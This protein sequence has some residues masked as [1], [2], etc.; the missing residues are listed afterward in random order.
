MAVAEAPL[1]YS[2]PD[3]LEAQAVSLQNLSVADR[4][5][6]TMMVEIAAF[7][8][9]LYS[10][11]KILFL[12][13]DGE[14]FYD[15]LRILI[16]A[17]EPSKL[18]SIQLMNVNRVTIHDPLLGEYLESQGLSVDLVKAG[19]KVLFFDLGFE[20]SLAWAIRDRFPVE[21]WPNLE[22][23][24]V[25]SINDLAPSFSL[26]T[27]IRDGEPDFNSKQ[28][29][30]FQHAELPKFSG[31]ASRY[32]Y[33][34]G[35]IQPIVFDNKPDDSDA[36]IDRNLAGLYQAQ[37][38]SFLRQTDVIEHYRSLIGFWHK[39]ENIL[40]TGTLSDLKTFASSHLRQK[41]AFSELENRWD[42]K[43][44]KHVHFLRVNDL[45]DYLQ[46]RGDFLD[47]VVPEVEL[48]HRITHDR[49]R[50]YKA[51]A[52]K[53]LNDEAMLMRLIFVDPISGIL[54]AER[55]GMRKAVKTAVK[56]IHW[57]YSGDGRLLMDI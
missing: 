22:S 41:S 3:V 12:A 33:G 34:D 32:G 21:Y 47:K 11:H 2:H 24:L 51:D 56:A 23:H 38:A 44:K 46:T 54:E 45:A 28:R 29:F 55:N 42:E 52:I 40:K 50:I 26:Y 17:T 35:K 43:F 30:A 25:Y 7:L 4:D 31:R 19:Q 36:I 39:V 5:R 14:V 6:F 48:H 9:V 16:D 15:S 13:R 37:L 10:E 49:Y 57:S 18:D 20:A 53:T 1:P 8:S 27:A